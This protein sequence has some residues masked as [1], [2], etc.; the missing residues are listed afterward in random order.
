MECD[1]TKTQNHTKLQGCCCSCIGQARL[2]LPH[3]K[4][5]LL[6]LYQHTKP[7]SSF[8][9]FC[10]TQ[11]LPNITE[12]KNGL[13]LRWPWLACCDITAFSIMFQVTFFEAL[14][15]LCWTQVKNHCIKL[16]TQDQKCWIITSKW[17]KGE[18]SIVLNLLRRSGC[19][20]VIINM[21]G[22][23]QFAKR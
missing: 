17:L 11:F 20:I 2:S 3:I 13:L 18:N 21:E 22:I 15:Q 12:R 8:S 6:N 19:G 14:K 5:V 1:S 9:S 23:A 4:P 10:W 7:L 16:N